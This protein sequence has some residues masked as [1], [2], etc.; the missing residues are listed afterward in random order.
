[1]GYYRQHLF[2]CMNQR[3]GGRAC[4]ND[5]GATAMK[6]YAK[7]RIKALGLDG[8]G[9]IRVSMAGCLGRCAEGPVLVIY[10]EGVWYTYKNEEDIEKIIKS[11][12]LEGRPFTPLELPA[13]E[14]A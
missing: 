9:G 3:E 8:P 7:K 14:E 10:P 1:M 13:G 11:H 12:V 6:D 2:F 5:K 4:C